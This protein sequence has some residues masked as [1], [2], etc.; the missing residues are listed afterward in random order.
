MSEL[1]IMRKSTA[2]VAGKTTGLALVLCRRKRDNIRQHTIRVSVGQ[3][4]RRIL[5][6]N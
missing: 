5:V 4:V 6:D 3:G 1:V 2:R